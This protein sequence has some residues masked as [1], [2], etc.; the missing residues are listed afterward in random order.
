MGIERL[1]QSWKSTIS[2][3]RLT[4]KTATVV[5]VRLSYKINQLKISQSVFT[6]FQEFCFDIS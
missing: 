2:N 1:R 4:R 5:P 3:E 6:V